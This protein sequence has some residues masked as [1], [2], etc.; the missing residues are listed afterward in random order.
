MVY[1][2]VKKEQLRLEPS[3]PVPLLPAFHQ[4]LLIVLPLPQAPGRE[5]GVRSCRTAPPVMEP[6]NI[7]V[8]IGGTLE[9]PQAPDV[10]IHVFFHNDYRVSDFLFS[11]NSFCYKVN[12]NS[13]LFFFSVS[14]NTDGKEPRWYNLSQILEF[15]LV[16]FYNLLISSYFFHKGEFV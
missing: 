10:T 16:K 9:R 8:V 6:T 14:R 4:Q 7:A 15:I 12:V 11:F 5:P 13:F 2:L 1:L 3:H